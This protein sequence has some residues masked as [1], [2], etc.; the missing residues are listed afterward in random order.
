MGRH[1]KQKLSRD[2]AAK[3]ARNERKRGRKRRDKVVSFRVDEKLKRRIERVADI[4][5]LSVNAWLRMTIRKAVD[6][7]AAAKATA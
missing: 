2:P 4:T 3:K 5:E 6:D 7:A 1:S